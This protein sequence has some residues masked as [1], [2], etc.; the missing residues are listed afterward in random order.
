MKYLLPLI[1]FT[2]FSTHAQLPPLIP[3]SSL[4]GN[5]ERA[6]PQISPD[7]K[8][9]A[10][11]A[12]FNGVLNVWITSTDRVDD[13]VVTNDTKRGIRQYYWM[14]DNEHLVYIQDRDGDENWHLY[15]VHLPTREVKDLT[16]HEGIQAQIIHTDPAFPDEM[17]VGMNL[18]DKR[19]HDVY[20]LNLQ[21]GE[22]KLVVENPGSIV[23]WIADHSFAVR[24]AIAQNSEGGFV[25]NVRDDADSAWRQLITWSSEEGF[26]TVYG[27]NSDATGLYIADGRG[28]NTLRLVEI[29]VT[30]GDTTVLSSDSTYDVSGVLLHPTR[31]FVQAVST[32]RERNEWMAL[33][34]SVARDLRLLRRASAGDFNVVSRDRSDST[35][36]ATYT[37]DNGPLYYFSFD[38]RTKQPTFLFTNRPALEEVRLANMQPISFVSRDGLTIHGY[39][40]IPPGDTSN[41]LPLV[42]NVHGGPWARDIWGYNPEV[43]WLANRGYACLQVNYRG[44][45]GYG[46]DFLNAGNREWGAKMLD[47]LVDGVRWAIEQGIADSTRVAIYGGSYGG[48]AALSAAAFT[49]GIFKCAVDLVGPSNLITFI[50][51]IPPYWAPFK[52]LLSRRIGDPETET[53]FLKSRSPLFS[54]DKI[55]IPLLVAQGANDPRVKKEESV[56]IVSALKAKGAEVEYLLFENEGHGFARPENRLKFYAAAEKFLGK[57]LGGRVEE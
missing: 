39:L 48:Y 38:R 6:L 16:P 7:G 44:S 51:S 23:G 34:T 15:S 30:T 14:E 27:F 32:Y 47:D 11:V 12:P 29:S 41:H 42:V 2:V 24:A 26:P 57:H 17:L 13:S 49:K 3:R 28:A 56:Q 46:K 20:R 43:Q 36:I 4:F 37:L 31:H 21:S 50:E 33:D 19:L 9:L 25:L 55:S 1:L 5:P 54:A 8:K 10:Y 18:R 53:E 40:T 22:A 52:K 35:W 45:T